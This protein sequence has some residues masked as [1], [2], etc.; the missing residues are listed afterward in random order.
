MPYTAKYDSGDILAYYVA[1]GEVTDYGVDR[2]ALTRWTKARR[3]EVTGLCILGVDV[4]FDDLSDALQDA[5]LGLAD[6]WEW[7][8]E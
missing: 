4:D 1:D 6:N 3:V 5:I 7:V 8:E 2:R